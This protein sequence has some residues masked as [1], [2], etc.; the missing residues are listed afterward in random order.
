MMIYIN[1][2]VDNY[3]SKSKSKTDVF[4]LQEALQF[5]AFEIFRTLMKYCIED[6]C[7]IIKNIKNTEDKEGYKLLERKQII[8]YLTFNRVYV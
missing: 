7:Y 8:D 2:F 6:A 4:T 3:K 1:G 5:E